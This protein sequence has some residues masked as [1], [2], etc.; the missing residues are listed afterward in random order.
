M[1]ISNDNA[2]RIAEIER[3][4]AG[5]PN[6]KRMVDTISYEYKKILDMALAGVD[7]YAK[8]HGLSAKEKKELEQ[9]QAINARR[10]YLQARN[11]ENARN[12]GFFAKRDIEMN[13]REIRALNALYSRKMK[14]GLQVHMDGVERMMSKGGKTKTNTQGKRK[15]A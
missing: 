6:Y 10:Y 5:N 1:A 14:N 11:Q 8:E 2:V 13:N 15:A 12:G 3:I 9:A 7:A 4:E